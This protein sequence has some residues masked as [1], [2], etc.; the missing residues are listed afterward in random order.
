MEHLLASYGDDQ[1]DDEPQTTVQSLKSQPPSYFGTGPAV[2]GSDDLADAVARLAQ[3][4]K[5]DLAEEVVN[6]ESANLT[7]DIIR[8]ISSQIS[9]VVT[10]SR[11]PTPPWSAA[12]AQQKKL[13]TQS[14]PAT[15]HPQLHERHQ[16]QPASVYAEPTRSRSAPRMRTA[17]RPT[18][19]TTHTPRATTPSRTAPR[20]EPARTRSPSLTDRY[21][22]PSRLVEDRLLEEGKMM[23]AR[24][25]ALME[26]FRHKEVKPRRRVI[27]EHRW[28]DVINR[29]EDSGR[30]R[31]ERIQQAKMD[32]DA[33]EMAHV[34]ARPAVNAHSKQ[35][36]LGVEPLNHRLND[37]IALKERH[38][39]ETK[40]RLERE[41]MQE[42]TGRPEI[43]P[44]SQAIPRDI[45][46][47]QE[48]EKRKERRI[49]FAREAA[50]KQALKETTLR[51]AI[52]SRSQKLVSR[53]EREPDAG[54][55]LFS[56]DA[57]WKQKRLNST[58]QR[59]QD[60]TFAPSINDRSRMVP[61]G[62]A[63]VGQRLHVLGM[64]QKTR[65][66]YLE[67]ERLAAEMPNF[68]PAMSPGS[69]RMSQARSGVT[70]SPKSPRFRPT[71][72][73]SLTP[74]SGATTPRGTPQPQPQGYNAGTRASP[75]LD[76]SG[77][78][79]VDYDPRYE[80]IYRQLG[81][82]FQRTQ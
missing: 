64:Q 67:S 82:M 63:P 28:N 51:P 21:S 53:H 46:T 10:D 77:V 33:R 49:S 43:N 81:A 2:R 76:A 39:E 1:S 37:I 24:K 70:P 12:A 22:S 41:R 73:A 19:A 16:Q 34:T 7:D 56:E 52:N 50:E 44:E 65:R 13:A 27:S 30:Q 40:R 25:E 18:T 4:L 48:W 31:T 57:Q 58:M 17:T 38:L 60:E 32:L 20:T 45:S 55:R 61:R 35:M 42:M 8:Q 59:S 29:M 26:E 68:T 80:S 75:A 79:V 78:T 36:T 9:N 62:D 47:L 3:L 11:Q 15:R 72:Q 74:R 5:S 23:R 54:Q 71:S 69:R 66:V 6:R 14:P